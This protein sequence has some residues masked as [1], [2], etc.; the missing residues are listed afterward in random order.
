MLLSAIEFE[1]VLYT[2]ASVAD[3]NIGLEVNTNAVHVV[4]ALELPLLTQYLSEKVCNFVEL[5]PLRP[6]SMKRRQIMSRWPQK[7]RNAQQR[8]LRQAGARI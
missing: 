1:E 5:A 3:D 4:V 6:S 8:S 2:I 7:I